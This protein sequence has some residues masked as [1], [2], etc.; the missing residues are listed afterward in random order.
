VQRIG[1]HFGIRT[2]KL[3]FSGTLDLYTKFGENK[4]PQNALPWSNLI[5]PRRLIHHATKSVE[6]LV[7]ETYTKKGKVKKGLIYMK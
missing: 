6:G 3:G 4:T 7:C 1:R 5:K 2:E